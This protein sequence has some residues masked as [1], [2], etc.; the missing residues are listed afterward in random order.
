[1]VAL[2]VYPFIPPSLSK[3]RFLTQE[4]KDDLSALLRQNSDA[5]DEEKFN[6]RGVQQAL[7]DP[8]CWG[9]AMLF[10]C[11]SFSLYS[12]TLFSPTIIRNLGFATWRAQLLSTPPYVIAFI[13]VMAVAYAS[14]KA[15]KRAIFIIGFDAL[16]IIGG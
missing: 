14:H 5:A 4:E 16:I 12:I 8:Q 10:H 7:T 15:N 11:H 2:A 3:A 1:M 6:W 9:Y 13:A